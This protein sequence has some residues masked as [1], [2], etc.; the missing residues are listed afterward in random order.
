MKGINH[1]LSGKVNKDNKLDHILEPIHQISFVNKYFE[2][3]K[4]NSFVYFFGGID[5]NTGDVTDSIHVI[6]LLDFNF[7][8]EFKMPKRLFAFSF[9]ISPSRG[10]YLLIGGLASNDS[11]NLLKNEVIYELSIKDNSKKY[12]KAR[13]SILQ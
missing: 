13:F 9:S 8:K 12:I 7:K 11:S 10:N 6:N 3:L 5:P 2:I 4:Y 1:I